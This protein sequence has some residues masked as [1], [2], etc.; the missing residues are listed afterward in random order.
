M[1]EIAHMTTLVKADSRGRVPIRGTK[2]RQQYLVTAEN[3]GWWV[4]PA[5]K[6]Q[7]PP[8]ENLDAPLMKTRRTKEGWLMLVG[9]FSSAKIAAAVRADRDSR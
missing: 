5:P 9:K 7:P 2:S 4:M 3:G 8:R 6:V 1:W